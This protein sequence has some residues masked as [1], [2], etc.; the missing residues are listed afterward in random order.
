[1]AAQRTIVATGGSSGLGFECVQHLLEKETPFRFILPVRDV[2]RTQAAYDELKYDRKLHSVILLP[3]DLSDLKAVKVAAGKILDLLGDD[4]I[5]LLMLNAGMAK[6]P[7]GPGPHGSKWSETYLVNHLSQHY[8]TL[9]LREKL[10]A[11]KTRI[12]YVSSRAVFKVKDAS[13]HKEGVEGQVATPLLEEAIVAGSSTDERSVYSATKFIQL[14]SAHWWRRQLQD[15][16]IVVAVT[17]ARIS[18]GITRYAPEKMNM[19]GAGTVQQGGKS[20]RAAFKIQEFP[21]DPEQIFLT[22]KA[23]WAPKELYAPSLDKALQDKWCPSVA[24]IEKS[25]GITA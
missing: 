13:L 12:V 1:M 7:A 23:E 14:L 3:T 6:K 11:S 19:T 24:E 5:G 20:I 25:E 21:E 2:Q 15:T 18:T 8:L 10:V 4:S 16:N 17:P 9:Q 22:E